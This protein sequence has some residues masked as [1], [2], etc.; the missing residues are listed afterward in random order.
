MKTFDEIHQIV[1]VGI[2]HIDRPKEPQDLYRPIDYV[3]SLGGKRLRP[4][5]LLMAYNLYADD[6]E[7]AIHPALGIEIF[8]NFTLLHDDIMDKADI[9]RG[10]PTVHK[11]WSDST[12]IL[13]G[14]VM[15]IEAYEHI[16]KTPEKYLKI[17]LD[18]FSG[19]AK[20][21]CE[22]QQYDL[23]FESREQVTPDD[24]IEM[25]RLKTSV[26]LGTSLK[27]GATIADAPKKDV[28]LLYDFGV[29]IGLAFQLKDDLLDVYGNEAYF[30][31]KIGGDILCN[32]KTYLLINALLLAEN[33]TKQELNGWLQSSDNAQEKIKAVTEIYDKLKVNALCEDKM[34]FFYQKALA[35]LADVGAA[36]DKKH[37]LRKLAEKLMDRK[38]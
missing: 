19:M 15:L 4:A 38:E 13:S 1:N 10:K 6:V 5:L 27:I 18:L 11:K 28:D 30:G 17:V 3:L 22:G 25:I 37:E 20:E 2:R 12:A 36:D 9:R 34:Q 26:L 35:N 23:Q 32:K 21:I 16:A 7:T 24:Y 8:H 14:D 29:N 33:E 31:K